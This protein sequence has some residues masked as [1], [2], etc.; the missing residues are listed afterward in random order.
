MKFTKHDA[1]KSRLDLLPTRALEFVGFVLGHGAQKYEPHN[2]RKCKDPARYCAATLRHV[3]KALR[4]E[5][6]DPESSLP[7][8]A[9]AA[10]SILFALEIWLESMHDGRVLDLAT[11]K[12]GNYFAI[13]RKVRPGLGKVVKR[14][15]SYEKAWEEYVIG[16]MLEDK[17]LIMTIPA[18][19]KVGDTYSVPIW[20]FSKS[21]KKRK[22]RK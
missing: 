21:K 12:R 7:H 5:S 13:L 11:G 10:T 16:C 14:F 15:K 19:V 20:H 2:W 4:D 1:R 22:T 9:H 3:M 17:Y 18:R 8:L 6:I